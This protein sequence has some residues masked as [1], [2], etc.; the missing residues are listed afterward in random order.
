[1]YPTILIDIFV[2]IGLLLF[3]IYL[4][5]GY[6]IFK[7]GW[8]CEKTFLK[9]YLIFFVMEFIWY[10][11]KVINWFVI[12]TYI[13]DQSYESIDFSLHESFEEINLILSLFSMFASSF[14]FTKL[15]NTLLY[16]QTSGKLALWIWIALAIYSFGK[17][18]LIPNLGILSSIT[19]IIILFKLRRCRKLSPKIRIY[20]RSLSFGLLLYALANIGF[21]FLNFRFEGKPL[22]YIFA[23]RYYSEIELFFF[24]KRFTPFIFAL[25][26]I[27]I[28][29]G[30]IMTCHLPLDN[31]KQRSIFGVKH[32]DLNYLQVSI[33][34]AQYQFG[35]PKIIHTSNS[36]K[37]K[38]DLLKSPTLDSNQHK[39]SSTANQISLFSPVNSINETSQ[40]VCSK[41]NARADFG[42]L[43]CP[44]C[45]RDL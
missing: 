45:G 10:L 26:M 22:Y 42:A 5:K 19:I 27:F 32:Q 12:S 23:G 36:I 31:S 18:S 44:K 17:I 3:L 38:V 33:Q 4:L 15:E 37:Q 21:Q 39:V 6:Q 35:N 11:A 7:L 25:S 34:A 8:N 14:F 24:L 2:L 29:Y 43:F 41:C 20:S 28:G 13:I 1:M 40:P 30:A 9:Y 16:S